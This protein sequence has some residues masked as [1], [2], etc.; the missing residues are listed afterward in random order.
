MSQK[1]GLIK[2]IAIGTLATAGAILGSALTYRKKVIQP[3]NDEDE[4][5]EANRRRANR[6]AHSAHHAN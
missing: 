2:G 4:R 5:I 6:K 1:S 3:V